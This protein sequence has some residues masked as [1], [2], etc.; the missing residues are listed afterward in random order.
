M[1]LTIS[2]YKSIHLNCQV[3][4]TKSDFHGNYAR[5]FARLINDKG[6]TDPFSTHPRPGTVKCY[7]THTVEINC[8][9]KHHCFACI[10]WHQPYPYEIQYPAPVSVWYMSRYFRGTSAIFMPVQRI[11]SRFAGVEKTDNNSGI[12]ITCPLYKRIQDV[13]AE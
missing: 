11:Y 6:E 12:L 4:T 8:V 13:S 10:D 5:V 3:Y 2:K 1:A 9:R 7:F